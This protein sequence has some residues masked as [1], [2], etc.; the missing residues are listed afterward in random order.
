MCK[1]IEDLVKRERLEERE[2]ARKEAEKAK[3]REIALRM[4]ECGMSQDVIAK[5]VNEP[6]EQVKAWLR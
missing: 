4:Q 3:S 1:E 6:V 5:C 2:I